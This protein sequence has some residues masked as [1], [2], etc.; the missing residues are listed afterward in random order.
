MN[1]P[2]YPD[3]NEADIRTI[4]S[5]V[6]EFFEVAQRGVVDEEVLTSNKRYRV[7]RTRSA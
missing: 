4:A 7:G 2:S 6:R 1:L 5:K 3:L